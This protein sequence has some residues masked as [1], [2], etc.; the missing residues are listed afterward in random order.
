MV[1]PKSRQFVSRDRSY[2]KTF[3]Q[4]RLN[5]FLVSGLAMFVT[6]CAINSLGVQSLVTTSEFSFALPVE[7]DGMEEVRRQVEANLSQSSLKSELAQVSQSGASETSKLF[8]RDLVS[9]QSAIEYT[10]FENPVAPNYQFRISLSGDGGWEERSLVQN[11]ATKIARSLAASTD[12]GEGVIRIEDQVTAFQ[13]SSRA[14][15]LAIRRSWNDIEEGIHQLEQKWLVAN[16]QLNSFVSEPPVS[17]GQ[18]KPQSSGTIFKQAS[19]GKG[20]HLECR[21]P[22][23]VLEQFNAGDLKRRIRATRK[24]IQAKTDQQTESAIALSSL[25]KRGA[26]QVQSVQQEIQTSSR[27]QGGVPGQK[28]LA[29]FGIVAFAVGWLV[30]FNFRP[31]L[32]DSGYGSH[33]QVSDALGLPVVA[34]MPHDWGAPGTR[35]GSSFEFSNRFVACAEIALTGFVL[36][37]IVTCLLEPMIRTSFFENPFHGLARI[38]WMFLGN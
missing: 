23:N 33:K 10:L 8:D 2:T 12:F 9:L 14:N 31:E 17:A 20:K 19:V 34:Q 5:A 25:A 30:S 28:R 7:C 3:R 24:L 32:L 35:S 13:S 26:R 16:Q 38:T 18:A 11:I 21:E 37:T 6:L 27:P 22:L 15:E 29:L 1:R 36:L 4:R